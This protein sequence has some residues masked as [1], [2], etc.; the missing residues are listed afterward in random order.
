MKDRDKLVEFYCGKCFPF[1]KE[2]RS[3]KQILNYNGD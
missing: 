3:K 2:G 1:M